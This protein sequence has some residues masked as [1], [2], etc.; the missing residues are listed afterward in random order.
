MRDQ[1]GGA[2]VNISSL[3]AVGAASTLTAYKVSKAGV[4]A[5]TQTLAVAY[6]ADGIRVNAIMPGLIDTPMAV[7]AAARA[8]GRPRDRLAAARARQVPLGH[9]GT[10]WDMAHAA[11]FLASD[12]VGLHHRCGAAGRRRAGRH[13]RLSAPATIVL[14]H[15][16]WHGAWCWE[17]VVSDLEADGLEVVAVDL[18]GHGD[19]PGPLGDLHDDAARVTAVLDEVGR[20]AVL[21]GHSYGGA[22]I[23][24]A[25]VH[26]RVRHLVYLCAFA[27]ELDESC[28]EAASDDPETRQLSHTGRP[29]VADGFVFGDDT[30][31]L[32]PTIAARCLYNDCDPRTIEWALARLG[33]QPVVTLGQSPTATAWHQV[34]STYVVCTDDQIVHPGLQAILARR[35]SHQVE[36]ATSHSPFLSQPALVAG[37]LGD[38]ARSAAPG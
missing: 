27:L 19:D 6:A 29:N 9:Q 32:E 21:V 30:I 20:D 2:I 26:P 1:G 14:V 35:C 37:L 3:A 28:A 16:A 5:L 22:V 8:A 36:W 31:T 38:I 17:R 18:P 25:G 13:G 11:L 23:T 10:A 7:D 33:P 12:E 24:E 4:N 15:G 34:E